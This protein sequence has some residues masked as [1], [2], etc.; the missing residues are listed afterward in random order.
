MITQETGFTAHYGGKGGLFSLS[1]MEE[2]IEAVAAICADYKKHSR[3]A[4]AIAREVFEAEKVLASLLDRA[5]V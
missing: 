5:G 2:I 4:L 1:S 3:A